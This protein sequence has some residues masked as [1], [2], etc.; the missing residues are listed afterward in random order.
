[1]IINMDRLVIRDLEESEYKGVVASPTLPAYIRAATDTQK[2]T[3]P[4]LKTFV[5]VSYVP[6]KKA[7]KPVIKK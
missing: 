7:P 5:M 4:A 6:K 1:M 2:T 3:K